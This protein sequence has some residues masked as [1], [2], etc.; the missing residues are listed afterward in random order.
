MNLKITFLIS[1]IFVMFIVFHIQGNSLIPHFRGHTF[2]KLS[3]DL[4]RD[5]QVKGEKIFE[6]R[7]LGD[8]ISS[9]GFAFALAKFPDAKSCLSNESGS[10]MET[11]KLDWKSIKRP[12]QAA[13]CLFN[14]AEEFDNRSKLKAWL[15]NSADSS[16]FNDKVEITLGKSEDL[17]LRL[18]LLPMFENHCF[19][20]L[21]GCVFGRHQSA[22]ISVSERGEVD[23]LHLNSPK[24]SLN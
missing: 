6:S 9:V 7:N 20:N 12:K 5:G 2:H 16:Y 10:L 3:I 13:V 15:K 22:I 8:M 17:Y 19:I 4:S 23:L 21:Y 11:S 14:I 24:I 18:N 1:A